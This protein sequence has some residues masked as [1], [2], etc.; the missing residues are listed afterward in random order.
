MWHLIIEL[1]EIRATFRSFA[2]RLPFVS[3]LAAPYIILNNN[4]ALI[5]DK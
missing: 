1:R 4:Y 5:T 3:T 2:G